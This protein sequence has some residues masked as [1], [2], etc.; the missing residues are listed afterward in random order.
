MTD[1]IRL[2]SLGRLGAAL[3]LKELDPVVFIVA[4]GAMA[5]A[6]FGVRIFFVQQINCPDKYGDKGCCSLV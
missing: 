3:N 5:W 6:V 2:P 4:V 1:Y